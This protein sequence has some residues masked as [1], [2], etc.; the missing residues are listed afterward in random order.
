MVQAELAG[1]D[2]PE[3]RQ[4]VVNAMRC[5]GQELCVHEGDEQ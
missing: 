1:N 2:E 3:L 4:A 5:L